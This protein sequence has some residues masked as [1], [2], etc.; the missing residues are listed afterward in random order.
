MEAGLRDKTTRLEDYFDFWGPDDIRIKGHRISIDDVIRYYW[1]HPSPS[2]IQKRFP[3]LTVEEIFASI[4]YYLLNRAV[5]DDML[6]R[7]WKR[8]EEDYQAWLANPSPLSQRL[9]ALAQQRNLE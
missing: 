9:R 2:E 4:T 7:Q 6:Y 8:D 1:D 5:L 3:T